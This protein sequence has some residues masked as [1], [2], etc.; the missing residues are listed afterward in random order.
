MQTILIARLVL[1]LQLVEVLI[2]QLIAGLVLIL[3]LIG[4]LV[5]QLVACPQLIL[6]A[7]NLRQGWRRL[8]AA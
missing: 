5:L 6:I 3:E 4:I 2:L 8:T 7:E 1:V